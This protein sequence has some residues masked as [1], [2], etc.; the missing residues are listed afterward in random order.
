MRG[1]ELDRLVN[2]SCDGVVLSTTLQQL[3]MARSS[4][5]RRCG[6]G[7]VWQRIL[8][9]VVL[10]H[11]GHPSQ[12]QRSIA[13]LLYGGDD[14][15]LTGTS[16]LVA[17]GFDV[18]GRNAHVL[19]PHTRSRTPT[20]FVHIERTWRMPNGTTRGSLRCAPVERAVLDA[21]R[22]MTSA[23]PCRAL[24]TKA[25]QRGDA[26]LQAL[27]DEL[28]A[29]SDRGSALPRT[30][31]GE[32]SANAHSIAELRARKLYRGFRLPN[33]VHNPDIVSSTGE[34]IAR[35]DGWIDSVA[36]GWEIDSLAHHMSVRDHVATVRRRERM[37]SHGI[38]VVTHLPSQLDDEPHL[39]ESQL[40]AGYKRACDRP[41]PN[42]HIKSAEPM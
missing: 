4:I 27:V 37:L 33:M 23:D 25:L 18:A 32:L 6:T 3:G 11:N 1:G 8:P 2:A 12:R 7:G 38:E 28:A 22:L 5:A 30:V 13:A 36:M 10:L 15:L 19:I 39:V 29:G 40:R 41:R 14:A 24:L 9:G 31:L 42:V 35:P 17:Y 34:F 26:S 16:A 20:A 21:C